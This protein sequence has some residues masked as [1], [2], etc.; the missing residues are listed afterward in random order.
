[1]G[2]IFNLWCI[3]IGIIVNGLR[4]LHNKL[5]EMNLLKTCISSYS[6]LDVILEDYGH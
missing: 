4:E 2:R 6:L 3:G 1:M 5:F